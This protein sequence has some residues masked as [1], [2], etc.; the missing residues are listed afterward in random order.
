MCLVRILDEM[1]GGECAKL[2]PDCQGFGGQLGLRHPACD[3]LSTGPSYQPLLMDAQCHNGI[4]YSSSTT[5]V[6]ML[7]LHWEVLKVSWSMLFK[8][9]YL[10]TWEDLFWEKAPGFKEPMQYKKLT[11]T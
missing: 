10:S 9:T 4:N 3:T 6:S 2:A 5:V 11:N 8:G 7:L 1:E